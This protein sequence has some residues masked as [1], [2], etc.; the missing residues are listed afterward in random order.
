MI[1]WCYTI[2]VQLSDRGQEAQGR[3]FPTGP[4]FVCT[5]GV[6]HFHVFSWLGNNTW[7]L[8]SL[9]TS[10]SS[11]YCTLYCCHYYCYSFHFS[12]IYHSFTVHRYEHSL[13]LTRPFTPHAPYAHTLH[14]PPY[15]W[16][17]LR[18]SYNNGNCRCRRPIDRTW[19]PSSFTEVA[20]V[21]VVWIP[22]S[23]VDNVHIVD[24]KATVCKLYRN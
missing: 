24:K 17:R 5:D 16:K 6:N 7:E 1:A 3:W 11:L 9:F 18:H 13:T 8:L 21:E 10:K 20:G 14:A 15:S 23:Y 4:R 12:F 2:P 22:V 19:P